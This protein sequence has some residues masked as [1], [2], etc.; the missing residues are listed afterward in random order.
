MMRQ[1]SNRKSKSSVPGFIRSKKKG[2]SS[3]R[4]K[5]GPKRPN[6]EAFGS[7]LGAAP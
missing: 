7:F 4:V 3:V 6:G 5:A 1:A 2:G